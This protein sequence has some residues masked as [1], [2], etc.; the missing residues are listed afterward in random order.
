MPMGAGMPMGDGMP[1]SGVMNIMQGMGGLRVLH[2]S[3]EAG[4]DGTQMARYLDRANASI[5]D[6]Y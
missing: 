3:K 6:Y 4:T 1:I 2:R 5:V